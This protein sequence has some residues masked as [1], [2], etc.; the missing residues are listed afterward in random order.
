M[1]RQADLPTVPDQAP[2]GR[3]G[4]KVRIPFDPERFHNDPRWSVEAGRLEQRL[5][6]Y[7][8]NSPQALDGARTA[9][10]R[11]REVL[12]DLTPRRPDEGPAD[13]ARRVESVFFADDSITSE[14]AGTGGATVDALLEHANV[15]ELVTA[16]VNAAYYNRRNPYVFGNA[17]LDIMDTEAWD[18]ARAAGLDVDAIRRTQHGEGVALDDTTSSRRASKIANE[19]LPVGDG[20]SGTAA[21]VLTAVKFLTLGPSMN[22]RFLGAVMACMLPGQNH[23]LFEVLRGAQIADVGGVRLEPGAW[24]TALDFYRNLPCLDLGTLRREILPDG[25]FPHESRYFANATDPAGFSETQHPEIG[26]LRDRLWPQLESGR[27]TDPDLAGWLHRNGIDPADPGKVRALGERLSPAHVMALTVYTRHSHYLINNVTRTHPWTPGSSPSLVEHGM[28]NKVNTLV[29]HYL[30]N[31]A[32]NTKALPLPMALRPML[33]VGDANL[34][35]TSPLNPLAEFY[36]HAV[37]RT[38]EASRRLEEFRAEGRTHEAREVG[39]ELREARREARAAFNAI[40]ERLGQVTPRLFD[41]MRRHADMV[42]EAMTQLPAVGSPD[43]PVRAYRGD[44]ITPLHS[45]VY[46]SKPYPYG[47]AREFLSVSRQMEVAIRFMAENPAGNRKVLVV[48]RLTGQQAR[49]VSVFSSY[50]VDEEAVFPPHSLTR[51]VDDPELAASVRAEADR[52]M[53]DMSWRGVIPEIPHAY[54]IIIMEEG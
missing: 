18:R 12:M 22:K 25:M 41:E 33:H 30:D 52:L 54:E 51:R 1:P 9:L 39:K 6:A 49:D 24:A 35:S 31:L 20:I 17:L 2:D 7:Y 48:Y 53:A 34:D 27:V 13:F 15:R 44:W 46:G 43:A 5:G 29:G 38:E 26:Y 16:F 14:E 36:V 32:A 10:R 19:D 21:K 4:D 28:V 11:M 50:A 8:V 23:S 47:T 3:R 45:P 40:K 42:H 37:R